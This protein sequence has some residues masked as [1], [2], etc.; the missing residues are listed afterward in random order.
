LGD[1]NGDSILS[2]ADVQAMMTALSNETAYKTP[3]GLSDAAL[4][5]LGDLNDDGALTNADV[6][7]LIS[8]VA[9]HG[10]GS[11][12]VVPEPASLIMA[13]AALMTLVRCGIGRAKGSV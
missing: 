1:F 13:I 7:S 9:N 5:A 4:L 8:L 2:A 12:A 6:Q 3:R 10:G 11:I